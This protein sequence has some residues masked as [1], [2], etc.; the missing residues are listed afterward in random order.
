MPEPGRNLS[1]ACSIGQI[2]TRFRH[3]MA[4]LLGQY[5]VPHSCF[6]DPAMWAHVSINIRLAGTSL[7]FNSWHAPSIQSPPPHTPMHTLNIP[8]YGHYINN[9]Y[10]RYLTTSPHYPPLYTCDPV[11]TRPAGSTNGQMGPPVPSLL[12]NLAW[13]GFHTA[14]TAPRQSIHQR[15]E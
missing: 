15:L 4:Y 8:P 12:S 7:Q 1:D 2:P 6:V 9:Q 11:H 14:N 13:L 5:Q 10:L 3:I